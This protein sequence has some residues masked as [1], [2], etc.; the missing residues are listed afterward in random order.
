MLLDLLESI[1]GLESK[2]LLGLRTYLQS[3]I[4]RNRDDFL[5]AKTNIFDLLVGN[6]EKVDMRSESVH[7]VRL[8]K[9]SD[10]V[11]AQSESRKPVNVHHIDHNVHGTLDRVGGIYVVNKVPG[12][13]SIDTLE[14]PQLICKTPVHS[15]YLTTIGC[16]EKFSNLFK[17]V[18]VLIQELVVR[19]ALRVV[20]TEITKI[21]ISNTSI[22][23]E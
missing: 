8:G 15:P 9:H 18:W 20:R 12:P 22:N 1:L 17:V 7:K 16:Q 2:S 13:V 3:V 11:S 21:V 5:Q 19:S 14:L 4:L 23:E 6:G 10:Q